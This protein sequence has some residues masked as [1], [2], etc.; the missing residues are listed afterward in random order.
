MIRVC[1]P[2]SERI[3]WQAYKEQNQGYTSAEKQWLKDH[4]ADEFHF[5]MAYG[6]SIYDEG[7]RAEGR[8][9]MR[10]LAEDESE[11]KGELSPIHTG[12]IVAGKN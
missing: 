7:E 10:T 9:I 3:R 6:L 11:V 2:E 8:R 12:I 1:L 4:W 5:L